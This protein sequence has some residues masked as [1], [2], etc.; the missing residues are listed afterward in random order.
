[1]PRERERV[2]ARWIARRRRGAREQ[3]IIIVAECRA[4]GTYRAA[5]RLEDFLKVVVV[6][7][8]DAARN[9][10]APARAGREGAVVREMK[11]DAVRSANVTRLAGATWR[12]RREVVVVD[13]ATRD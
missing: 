6:L 12:A 5:H 9:V 4:S 1:M 8:G 3:E 13:K 7:A 2:S 11:V 10:A